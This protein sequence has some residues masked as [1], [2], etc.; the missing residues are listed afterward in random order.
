[1]KSAYEQVIAGVYANLALTGNGPGSSN[2]EGIDAGTSQ[3]GRVLLYL[4]TL[5]ADQMIW[6]YEND[7]GTRE[8]QRNIWTAQNPLILGMFSRTHL[9]VAFANNF[10]RETT[11]DKL[12]SR[13]VS[14][15]IREDIVEYRAEARLLESIILL[16]Y[17]GSVRKSK[18]CNRKHTGQLNVRSL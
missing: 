3:F 6:S 17:D 4:Q 2:I 5:S 11:D 13:N 18:L 16:L 7:P 12:D 9:T 15:G 10:L 14:E 1:M 8:L